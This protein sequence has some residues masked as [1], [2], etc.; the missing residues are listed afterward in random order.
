MARSG[1]KQAWDALEEEYTALHALL[2]ARKEAGLT[3]PRKHWPSAWVPLKVQ[4]RGWRLHCA[5]SATPLR[6]PPSKK[7]ANACGKRLVAQ[8]V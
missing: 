7:Y 5:T 4:C 1:F 3:Q 8:L 6:F 2:D